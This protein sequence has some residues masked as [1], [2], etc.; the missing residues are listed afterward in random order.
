MELK[1]LL[2]KTGLTFGLYMGLA[3][4]G[5][6]VVLYVL[7]MYDLSGQGDNKWIINLLN[8]ALTI[9]FIILA[10]RAFKAGGDGFMT[11]GEGFRLSFTTII[12]SVLVGLVWLAVYMLV[13]E[14][15][16]QE[17]IIDAQ[18]AQLEKSGLEDDAI[19]MAIGWTEKMTSPLFMSL[20]TIV[21]SA[22]FAVIVSLLMSAFF[23]KKRP[24]FPTNNTI[25]SEI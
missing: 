6:S 9:V 7:G 1:S 25:D 15:N 12:I 16:Y 13:L 14:P 17:Y 11:F 21:T 3:S 10:Y 24:L 5:L 20:W 18:V 22:V 4:I 2:R 23:Q 19:D 8:F